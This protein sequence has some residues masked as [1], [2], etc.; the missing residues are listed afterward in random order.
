MKPRSEQ[1]KTE[2][3]S[4]SFLGLPFLLSLSPFPDARPGCPYLGL[5]RR[6]RAGGDPPG[7]WPFVFLLALVGLGVARVSAFNEGSSV[8]ADSPEF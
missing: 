8:V 1:K 3:A 4:P 6:T 5:L 7:C 2:A